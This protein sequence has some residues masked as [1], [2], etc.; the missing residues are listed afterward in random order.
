[1]KKNSFWNE[2]HIGS[3]VE[4]KV[5]IPSHGPQLN[6]LFLNDSWQTYVLPVPE[7]T[8]LNNLPTPLISVI[9]MFL[10]K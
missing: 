8:K 7:N 3:R 9:E 10:L 5:R 4:R 6:Q 2:F 1:M